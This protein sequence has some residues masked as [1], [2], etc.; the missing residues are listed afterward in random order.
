P[1]ERKTPA[2]S[3]SHNDARDYAPMTVDGSVH[4]L[5]IA[6][7]SR[8]HPLYAE[9]LDLVKQNDFILE[10]SNRKWWLR[11]RHKTLVFLADHLWDLKRRFE[12]EFT[13]NFE[14]NLA[15]LEEAEVVG[16][17]AEA[18]D[19]YDLELSV[20][21]KGFEPRQIQESLQ[22]GRP[23]LE[24]NG[25]LVLLPKQKLEQLEEVRRLLNGSARSQPQPHSVHRLSGADLAVAGTLLDS[26]LPAF[27]PPAAW[28]DRAE[29]LGNI[30]RLAPP[31]LPAEVDEQL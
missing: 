7:P 31:P 27:L 4:F 14:T 16:E 5:A 11:D 30:S 17:A 2:E 21:A 23:Y 26:L 13:R 10:P 24:R 19:G 20:R 25:R 3:P 18:S 15:G 22:T 28:R 1:R 6:L 9:A 12:A 29:A 8:E